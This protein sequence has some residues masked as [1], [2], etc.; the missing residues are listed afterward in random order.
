MLVGRIL[1]WLF[2]LS[3]I[4]VVAFEA[5]TWLLVGDYRVMALGEVWYRL[6]R[7]SL[8][9][10]QA[11]IERHVAPW[12]WADLVQPTLLLPAWVVLGVPGLFLLLVCGAGRPRRR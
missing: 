6:D 7:A 2:V 1:G 8:N 5:V 9:L 10:A 4:A 11:G 12:L 3:A